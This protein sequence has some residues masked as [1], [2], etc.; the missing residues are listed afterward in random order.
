MLA[1][2]RLPHSALALVLGAVLVDAMGFGIVAPVLPSLITRLGHMDLAAASRVS[3][4]L[5]G[6]FAAG[7]FVAAPILGQLSDRFGRRP[8]LA[9]AMMAFALDYG[10]MALAPSLA[11]LFVGRAVAGAAGAVMGPAGAVLADVTPP[12]HRSAAFGWLSGAWGAGF[13]LGPAVG[14]MISSLGP[15]APFIVAAGLAA[16]D[17]VAILLVMRETLKPGD[18]RGLHWRDAHMLG[19]FRPLS[20]VGRAAPLVFGWALWQLSGAVYPA[21]WAFWSTVRFGWGPRDIGLSL[22]YVGLTSVL[23]QVFVT[24]RTVA[25]LGDRGAALLGLGCGAFAFA[26]YAFANRAWQVYAIFLVG[27]LSNL[28]Y[29]AMSG[30]LSQ[31]VE[32]SHQGAL[33]GG[34]SSL[35]GLAA[36]VGPLILTQIFAWGVRHGFP[37]AAF[38]FAAALMAGCIAFVARTP[39]QGEARLI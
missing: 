28:A 33:Q 38:L 4:W 36:I 1:M 8:I 29:A 22:A 23:V 12:D 37:G 13:I 30:L 20:G 26:A 39:R 27:A 19:A 9:L 21:T 25:L 18:R 5:V 34:L 32:T 15:R 11:W 17:A 14:G 2:P 35:S 7:Q 24:G 6:V 31:Q 16:L 10:V 3:G